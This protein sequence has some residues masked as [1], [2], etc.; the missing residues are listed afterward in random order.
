M[1]SRNVKRLGRYQLDQRYESPGVVPSIRVPTRLTPRHYSDKAPFSVRDQVAD[2]ESNAVKYYL[3]EIVHFDTA[4][5]FLQRPSN[6]AV[7]REARLVTLMADTTA[8]THLNDQQKAQIQND[9]RIRRKVDNCQRLKDEIKK[10]G[11]RPVKAAK[12]TALYEEKKQADNDLNREWT[13]LR[14]KRRRKARKRHFRSSDTMV[15]NQQFGKGPSS[16]SQKPVPCL[17][18]PVYQIRERAALV[19]LICRSRPDPTVEEEHARR[20]KCMKLWIR[21]QDRHESSCRG[22]LAS[23]SKDHLEP[24]ALGNGIISEKC[25]PLQCPFCLGNKALPYRARTRMLSK[26]SNL[27]DHVESV[28]QHELAAF[29]AG[30]KQRGVCV[31]RKKAFIPKSVTH[32]K[33]HTQT[34]RGIRLR[35]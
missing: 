17:A 25:K 6:E 30:Q 4:A 14:E 7:Q 10:E 31:A 20:V 8:L 5:A 12:G 3:N 24:E 26:T 33:N 15:L 32:F 29:G 27:W 13:H 16:I 28:H 35:V 2:H 11:Y 22:T 1:W 9:A 34:G 18:P 21:W 19:E 23:L